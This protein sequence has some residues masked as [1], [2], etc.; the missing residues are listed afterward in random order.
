[1]SA[2][3]PEFEN[4]ELNTASGLLDWKK[5]FDR[6]LLPTV[7]YSKVKWAKRRLHPKE[8]LSA[9]DVPADVQSK[10]TVGLA[11]RFT[12][13]PIPGKVRTHVLRV[14]LGEPV[15]TKRRPSKEFENRE[16]KR[17]RPE[18]VDE[19]EETRPMNEG[20]SEGK[21]ERMETPSDPVNVSAARAE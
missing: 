19:E 14:A 16:S 2:N 12:E 1:L 9:L 4:R 5:R 10:I 7:W 17:P 8:L 18:M 21:D 20:P 15:V 13:M 3:E 11:H 6:V